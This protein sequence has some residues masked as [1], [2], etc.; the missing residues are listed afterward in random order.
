MSNNIYS[1]FKSFIS[2][3]IRGFPEYSDRING[4]YKETLESEN[5][6]DP[7]FV[8][9]IN[10]TTLLSDKISENDISI[11]KTDPV[12]LQNVSFKVIWESDISPQT[13]NSIWKYLQT[14]CIYGIKNAQDDEKVDEVMKMIEQNEKVKD[15]VTV[16]NMKKLKKLSESINVDLI[17]ENINTPE[18]KEMGELFENTQIGKIAKE[19]TDELNI[20]DMIKDSNGVVGVDK[21]FNGENMMN[22]VQSITSKVGALESSGDEENM[23]KEAMDITSLM[24]NNPLFDSLM[25]GLGDI[26][27]QQPNTPREP[28]AENIANNSRPNNTQPNNNHNPQQTRQ[29]LQNK[30][31]EREQNS[32]K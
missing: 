18:M 20:E 26:G 14:F 17:R 21:L 32:K 4:Y 6:E 28:Q 1:I 19:V 11:F 27:L 10:N 31:K 13:R 7:K 2:E 25:G 30:L 29:R 12:I 22:I 15:K 5:I 23:M 16:A 9:F 3:I 8:E 24:K